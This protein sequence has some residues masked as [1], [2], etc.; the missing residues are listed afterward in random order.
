MQV[1][2]RKIKQGCET[3]KER[4][5]INDLRE[6]VSFRDRMRLVVHMSNTPSVPMNITHESFH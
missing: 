5:L 4:I 1:L 3:N 2:F 6:A